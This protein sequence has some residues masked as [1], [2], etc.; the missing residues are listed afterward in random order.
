[1]HRLLKGIPITLAGALRAVLSLALPAAMPLAAQEGA[2]PL[3]APVGY[4]NDF[5]QLLSPEQAA[6]L[7]ALAR[8]VQTR[9]RGEMVIVTLADLGGRPVEEVSLR[10]G[11][12]WKV[13]AQAA[14]G[15]AARNAGVVILIVPKETNADGKGHCR[16]ETGN[17]AEG[18]IT[19]ATA[20]SL[21]RAAVPQFRDGDYAGAIETVAYGVADAFAQEFGV[22]LDLSGRPPP[23][24]QEWVQMSPETR[25][26]LPYF[27]AVFIFVFLTQNFRLRRRQ[28]PGCM[29]CLPL[30][31]AAPPR[32]RGS[33][34]SESSWS[35]GSD[36][37]GSSGGFGGFG[38]GGG[39]SGGGGGSSW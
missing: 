27:I 26:L 33:S 25:V 35:G 18:F 4:V 9:T 10:L 14:I 23:P 37:G 15:D 28:A 34:S 17:G 31:V 5:A 21:C 8:Q 19:D 3:P 2:L 38:G 13:G 7:D 12:E 16:I 29:G 1:M 11:R 30:I 6:R 39:F 32:P 22:T 24:E 36:W 20:G